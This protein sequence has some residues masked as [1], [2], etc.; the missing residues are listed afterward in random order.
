MGPDLSGGKRGE[1]KDPLT[2]C[3]ILSTLALLIFT[4]VQTET[5]L[6]GLTQTESNDLGPQGRPLS[7]RHMSQTAAERWRKAVH[8]RMNRRGDLCQRQ[9]GAINKRF[10]L[11]VLIRDPLLA[12][13]N[14]FLH[15]VVAE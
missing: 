13:F 14:K 3:T 12:L 11:Q 4:C 5:R 15:T 1:V 9:L 7:G 8:E 2:P 10:K 6:P